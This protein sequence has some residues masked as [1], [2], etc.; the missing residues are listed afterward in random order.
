M[1]LEICWKDREAVRPGRDPCAGI[2]TSALR[3]ASLPTAR[4][5]DITSRPCACSKQPL[6]VAHNLCGYLLYNVHIL[7]D[8]NVPAQHCTCT[9]WITYTVIQPNNT[10][11]VL[12]SFQSI[13]YVLLRKLAHDIYL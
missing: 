5:F 2:L 12:P 4:C 8:N 6:Y 1:F 3:P 13:V 7:N 10:H 11:L 9:A